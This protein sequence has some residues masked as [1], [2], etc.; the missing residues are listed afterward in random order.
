M[1]TPALADMIGT[2]ILSQAE[3]EA[4]M[5]KAGN[6]EINLLNS[7]APYA[8]TA[9]TVPTPITEYADTYT[10]DTAAKRDAV[11]NSLG[12]RGFTVFEYLIAAG[13]A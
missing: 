9:N 13:G 2:Y 12:P 5:R 3:M 8:T 10:L 11:L 1:A 6:R 4:A 7:M